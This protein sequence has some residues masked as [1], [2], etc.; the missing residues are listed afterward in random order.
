MKKKLKK[1]LIIAFIIGILLGSFGMVIYHE[2]KYELSFANDFCQNADYESFGGIN[3]ILDNH[4]NKLIVDGVSC[5]IEGNSFII[6]K[7]APYP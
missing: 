2:Y 3:F 5:R 1:E 7:S 6:I 4:T